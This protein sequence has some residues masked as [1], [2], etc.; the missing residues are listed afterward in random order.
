MSEDKTT[1]ED[2][3][4]ILSTFAG[5]LSEA[6]PNMGIAILVYPRDKTDAPIHCMFNSEPDGRP[7]LMETVRAWLKR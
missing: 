7:H 4:K 6:I 3:Q 5:L 2:T 1:I